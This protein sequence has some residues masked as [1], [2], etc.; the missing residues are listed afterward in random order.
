MAEERRL[1]H[2]LNGID[3]NR[4][5]LLD[6]PGNYAKVAAADREIRQLFVE[7][8]ELR[9]QIRMKSPRYAALTDPQPLSLSALQRDVL[10]DETV[11]LTYSLGAEGSYLWAVTK[12]GI[13]SYEL[14]A[15]KQVEAAARRVHQLL[16]VSHRRQ[17]RRE[18]ERA[19]TELA[20][21]V[22]WPART[23][24]GARRVA[25]VADGALQLVPFAA[26]PLETEP[27]VHRHEV[28]HLPSAST[29][30]VVRQ[31]IAGRTRAPKAVA[32]FADPVFSRDDPR[33]SKQ[34]TPQ[35]QIVTV[36][37]GHGGSP[38]GEAATRPA[39]VVRASRASG[40]GQLDRLV[41][42]RREAEAI[43]ALAGDTG[44]YAAF[45]FDASRAR[46]LDGELRQYRMLHF[47]THGLLNNRHSNLSGLVLSLVDR[48]GRPLDGFL[49][50]ND[51]YNLRLTADLV[52][53]S[54]CRTAVG[55]VIR[56]EGLISMVRSF[57][58][59]GAPR[60]V[61]SLWD[62]RDDATSDLMERFY[63]GSS[64]RDS[65]Q[66]PPC[67]RPRSGCRNIRGG[68][69]HT[70]GPGS[71][72]RVNGG[73]ARVVIGWPPRPCGCA[74]RCRDEWR[75]NPGPRHGAGR[76][77]S[78]DRSPAVSPASGLLSSSPLHLS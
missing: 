66:R 20:R 42:T 10:D 14:P 44:V 8:R 46:A 15:R 47:A 54:A 1:E 52:V 2:R 55:E 77:G 7:L 26:L 18:A 61:A 60:V 74:R 71:S 73:E 72:C 19:L 11:L 65:H 45:D 3:A 38:T 28:V 69:H 58:Y 39:D 78:C 75:S 57:M 24:L 5:R 22:L 53:L 64:V 49:R 59:A 43:R 35:A 30:A 33:V 6:R 13:T 70:S 16:T 56:G 41:S 31:E 9:G 48:K 25:I 51:I 21:M 63:R 12:R 62:V 67:V 4:L 34:S 17:H 27:L 29:L 68:V 23:Q 36:Q 50:T 32:L 76:R 40:L 37:D